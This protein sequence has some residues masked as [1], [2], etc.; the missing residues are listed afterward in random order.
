M[1]KHSLDGEG[2]CDIYS[3]DFEINRCHLHI[4]LNF[5]TM[6]NESGP[7]RLLVID[8]KTF[9]NEGHC[10]VDLW[11]ND[12]KTIH[13]HF[14]ATT[15]IITM[16]SK[17][18]HSQVIVRKP[19]N[20]LC[21][22][23][24]LT[25]WPKIRKGHVLDMTNLHSKLI[26]HR[27][28]ILR[29]TDRKLFGTNRQTAIS[30]NKILSLLWREGGITCD[31]VKINEF[32]KNEQFCKYSNQS[33]FGMIKLG[34]NLSSRQGYKTSTIYQIDLKEIM[35]LYLQYFPSLNH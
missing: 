26:D 14:L 5:Q 4:L 17:T 12:L 30:K 27:Q 15:K 2:H 29:V 31:C 34:L 22:R 16:F 21:R 24:R 33:D 7:K 18:K 28:E 19:F 25:L 3:Y 11:L 8:R 10:D 32:L 6:F 1:P 9:Y 13:D 20:V 35:I 23:S